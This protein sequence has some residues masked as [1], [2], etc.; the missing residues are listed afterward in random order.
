MEA[1]QTHFKA[2]K[3]RLDPEEDQLTLLYKHFGCTRFLYN[4]FLKEKQDHYQQNKST[5]NYNACSG[6]LTTLKKQEE[7][8]WLCEVN[9]QCLQTSLKNLE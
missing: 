2:F 9:S 6:V 8:E 3:F 5:L 4:Y 7:Y 1:N